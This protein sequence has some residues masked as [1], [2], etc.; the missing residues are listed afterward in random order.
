V[1]A[2][3]SPICPSSLLSSQGKK[4]REKKRK[5]KGAAIMKKW[6]LTGKEGGGKKHRGDANCFEVEEVKGK[7][8]G[9]NRP[10]KHKLA[11]IE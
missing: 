1:F 3:S 11:K 2:I 4:G 6:A 5:E 10:L 8:G 7:E 9:V